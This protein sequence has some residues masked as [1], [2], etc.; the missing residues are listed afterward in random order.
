MVFTVAV[1][2]DGPTHWTR[3]VVLTAAAAGVAGSTTGC[4][5]FEST[6]PQPPPPDP[7]EPM[8]AEARD[9]ANRYARTV[10]VHPELVRLLEPLQATHHAHVAALLEVID[11]PELA[12]PSP[13]ASPAAAE[14]RGIPAAED[15]ALSELRALEQ[16]AQERAGQ[17]CLQA[18]AERAELL[19]S[20][21]AARA[22]HVQVLL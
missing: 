13:S 14:S 5:W 3:R 6:P 4:A 9:L 19:G 11:R 21:C 20:I 8:L 1:R 17:A 15:E 22:S 2:N 10:V 12:T 18:P 16:E 7:L